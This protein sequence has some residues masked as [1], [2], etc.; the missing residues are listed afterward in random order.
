MLIWG[1]SA[2]KIRLWGFKTVPMLLFTLSPIFCTCQ[3]AVM[4]EIEKHLP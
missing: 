4:G 3:N 2:D 1:I